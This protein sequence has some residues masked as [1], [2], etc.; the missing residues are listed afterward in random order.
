LIVVGVVVG[1]ETEVQINTDVNRLI[2]RS[3]NTE[4]KWKRDLP[5]LIIITIIINVMETYPTWWGIRAFRHTKE[6]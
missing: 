4:E 1:P 6:W 3:V 2:C 5:K